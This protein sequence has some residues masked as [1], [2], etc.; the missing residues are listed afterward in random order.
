MEQYMGTMFDGDIGN[1]WRLPVITV[2]VININNIII[3]ISIIMI[4]VGEY[5]PVSAGVPRVP[6]LLELLVLLAL[7]VVQGRGSSRNTGGQ[8]GTMTVP[9]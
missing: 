7:L 2:T 4:I 1:C 3:T 8:V 9:A 6:T 5:W